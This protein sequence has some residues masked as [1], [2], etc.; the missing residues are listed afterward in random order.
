M[1][2]GVNGFVTRLVVLCLGDIA[3][4][5]HTR[6]HHVAASGG[7]V[8]RVERVEGRRR[9]RQACNHRHFAQ[10]QL[11]GRLAKVHLCRSPHAVS[12]VAEIDLVQVQLKNFI[13]TQQLLNT[14]GQEGFLDFA[15]QRFF[16][17]EEEVTRQ[18]LGNGTG[19][20]RGVPVDQ[21][22]AGGTE[23]TNRVN[24][25]VLIEAAIFGG[26]ERFH[27]FGWDLAKGHWNTTLLAVLRNELTVCAIDLHRYLQAHVF[28]R[29]DVWQLRLNIFVEAINRACSQQ[30]ATDCKDE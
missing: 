20:L 22:D 15:H 13:F 27:H 18:L 3:F 29:S 4:A 23:D 17:A 6:Q 1:V 7:A 19:P 16:R 11:V 9:L 21:R 24:P 25:V 28:Q 30:N 12:A 26:N 14:D 5:Q 8:K 2:V 10:T